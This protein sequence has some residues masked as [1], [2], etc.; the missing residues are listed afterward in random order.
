MH[1]SVVFTFG[2][3]LTSLVMLS[4]MPIINNSNSILNAAIA[5]GYDTY[6]D[7]SSYSQYSTDDKKYE[8][9]TGPFEGFFVSSVEFCKHIKFEDKDRK[10]SKVG[11]QGPQGDRGDKGDTGTT[12]AQGVPGI[13]GTNWVNGTQGPPGIVNAELC[14]AGTDLQNVYVLNGTTVV[15]CDFPT[16]EEDAELQC[17]ECIKYWSHAF[18]GGQFRNFINDLSEFINSINFNFTADLSINHPDCEDAAGPFP[19]ASVICLSIAPSMLEQNISQVF[20]LCE[21]F[22]LAILFKAQQDGTSIPEAFEDFVADFIA[23]I[24]AGNPQ[25]ARVAIAL[26]DCLRER[27]VPNLE[28]SQPIQTV[29]T[30]QQDLVQAL[31]QNSISELLPQQFTPQQQGPSSISQEQMH[32]QQIVNSQP[33]QTASTQQ[34]TQQQGPSSIS[35]EQMHQQQIV[36]LKQLVESSLP[37]GPFIYGVPK[38]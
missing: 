13:N 37:T 22:E 33:I 4:V 27:V 18:D 30:Q 19:N 17:E 28:E 15:S 16:P 11:P 34:S 5:Q 3:L 21:Q 38:H 32:Q 12:G 9:R 25:E 36:K 20:D 24:P 1:K 6:G 10:D 35:Q 23:A 29:S 7:S 31:Q 14:P 26:M 2:V 8:C